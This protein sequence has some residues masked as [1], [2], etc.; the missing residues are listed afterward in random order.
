MKKKSFLMM[1]LAV[2]SLACCAIESGLCNIKKNLKPVSFKQYYLK[3]DVK[4][5]LQFKAPEHFKEN[6]YE[7]IILDFTGKEIGRTKLTRKAG[8]LFQASFTLPKGFYTVIIPTAPARFGLSVLPSAKADP[9]FCMETLLRAERNSTTEGFTAKEMGEILSVMKNAGITNI[10]EFPGL[11][12][13]RSTSER[14]KPEWDLVYHTVGSMGM[15][16]ICAFNNVPSLY[17]CNWNSNSPDFQPYPDKVKEFADAVLDDAKRRQPGLETF[18]VLNEV[19]MRPAP[20]D[21][22]GAVLAAVSYTFKKNNLPLKICAP[23]LASFSRNESLV[24]IFLNNGMTEYADA[25]A[26]HSYGDPTDVSRDIRAFRKILK[27]YPNANMPVWYT[28]CGMPWGRG[29]MPDKTN[30]H[31]P[32][33]SHP[34]TPEELKSAAWTTMKAVEA[35]LCGIERYYPFVMKYYPENDKN[36]GMTDQQW[37]PLLSINAYFNC[38]LEIGNMDY[39]GNPVRKLA[40]VQRA[41]IFADN[42]R[43]VMVVFSPAAKYTLD[44]AGV[45]FTAVRAIDGSPVKAADNKAEISGHIAYVELD[46]AKYPAY[47]NGK[48]AEMSLYKVAKNYTPHRRKAVPV[49]FNVDSKQFKNK[50]SSGYNFTGNKVSVLAENLSGKTCEV[51]PVLTLPPHLKA[52]SNNFG[53]KAVLKSGERKVLEWTLEKSKG[54]ANF[55]IIV[56]DKLGNANKINIPLFESADLRAEKMGFNNIRRWRMNSCG[57]GKIEWDE[58]ENALKITVDFGKMTANRWCYPKFNLR[59]KE[60]LTK[61][62][63]IRYETKLSSESTAFP[64]SHLVML[65]TKG[66]DTRYLRASYTPFGWEWQKSTVLFNLPEEKMANAEFI[67]IGMHSGG[68]KLVYWVRNIE[69]LFNK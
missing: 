12:T 54:K 26:I 35:K 37:A 18:Q 58:A 61:A 30:K 17:G 32:G 59:P 57:K 1:T 11:G 43:A 62:V 39:K 48:T 4:H 50:N 25:L 22:V 65:K 31:I 20:P 29:F 21:R 55:N 3:P 45:P 2:L 15:K 53:T 64:G 7:C 60:K 44:L 14:Y 41:R 28:E 6:S 5:E 9:F 36:F 23:G 66:E 69:I 49:I 40:G 52:V 51:E 34:D 46:F 24:K 33:K 38:I 16:A 13:T 47:V 8:E 68:Q 67:N 27:G 56:S 42:Q 19:D 63:G 10:R